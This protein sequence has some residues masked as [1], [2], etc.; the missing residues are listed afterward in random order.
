MG[1]REE[2]DIFRYRDY[3]Q[4]LRDYYCF[5]K[6]TEYGFSYRRFARAVESNSPNYLKLVAEGKRNLTNEMATRF[7][8]ACG[9][10]GESADYFCDLVLF[11]QA[12]T[13]AERERWY[14]RITRYKRYGRVFKLDKAHAAYHAEWYIPAIREMAAME[15]F[16]AEPKWIAHRLSP[17]I[18]TRQAE[19]A[20]KTLLELN[21]LKA[22]GQGRLRQTETLVSTGEGPLGYHVAKFHHTMLN[23]ASHALDNVPRDQR[24]FGTL[25]LCMSDK[26]FRQIKQDLYEFR[27]R[28]LQ[29]SLDDSQCKFVA[30]VSFQLF[31]LTTRGDSD[32]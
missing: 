12:T 5:R 3:R 4:F 15:D 14:Q 31:P 10:K 25:T 8:K 23:R 20:L 13:D 22:D 6:N 32:D 18:T 2:I 27:Q 24:E 7:A 19:R 26:R 28:L 1:V 21:L 29:D 16:R 11:N 9:L 30:Q 17:R